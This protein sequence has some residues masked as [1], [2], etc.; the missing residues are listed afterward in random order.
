MDSRL[1]QLSHSLEAEP[2]TGKVTSLCI[3]RDVGV[4]EHPQTIELDKGKG[5]LGDRWSWKTWKHLKNGDSDPRVQVA[6]CNHR[7]IS[8]FQSESENDY[9]PGDNIIVDHDLS[10]P[11]FATGKQFKVGAAVLEVSDV[12]NDACAKFAGEFGKEVIKWIN[13]PDHRRLNLRGI[14]CRI[15]ENGS[16]HLGDR[17]T[18]L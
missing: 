3:R 18:P 15:I 16:I 2:Y 9:H 12:F 5:V 11:D 6:V 7:I 4:R 13:L 17:L 8:L 10:A 1:A 14:Y